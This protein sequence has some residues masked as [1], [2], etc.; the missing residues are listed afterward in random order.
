MK[1]IIIK[2]RDIPTQVTIKR[3]RKTLKKALLSPRF[4]AAVDRAAMHSGAIDSEAYL[5]DWQDEVI[6]LPLGGDE[7]IATLVAEKIQQLEADFPPKTLK[8]YVRH[9]GYH[10]P[11][12]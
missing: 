8:Q 2:W 5:Q 3:G 6:E 11:P 10:L 7:N 4:M 9:G 12:R 1:M